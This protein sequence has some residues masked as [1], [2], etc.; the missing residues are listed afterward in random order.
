MDCIPIINDNGGQCL[1]IDCIYGTLTVSSTHY[2]YGLFNSRIS[3]P[4]YTW[5]TGLRE[6][7]QLAQGS[8]LLSIKAGNHTNPWT[9]SRAFSPPMALPTIQCLPCPK[10]AASRARSQTHSPAAKT[11]IISAV[12]VPRHHKAALLEEETPCNFLSQT[13]WLWVTDR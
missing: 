13:K 1:G 5:V 8:K 10:D 7:K 2:L 12:S 9:G 6:V 11:N 4:H 3:A